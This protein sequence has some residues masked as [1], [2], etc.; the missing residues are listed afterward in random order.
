MK[1]KSR[2]GMGFKK[3]RS[4]KRARVGK[5]LKKKVS[6]NK[7]S[8]S[9]V[10]KSMPSKC[11]LKVIRLALKKARSAVKEAGGK[12]NIEIP[13]ILPVPT[14]TDGILS[15]VI[16]LFAGLSATGALTG[17]AAGIAKAVNDAK[18]AK[19]QLEENKRH[20]KTM[21]SVALGNGLYL[22][23]HKVGLGLH[24][25]KMFDQIKFPQRVLTDADILKYAK[26][27]K[28]PNFR[29]VFMRNALPASEPRYSE[30]A[31]VNLDN[32]SG[33][34]THWVV[35]R[36][37]G[38]NVVYY[39]SF[40]DLRPPLDLILYL[41]VDEV[42]YNQERFQDFDIYNCGHLCLKFLCAA[43]PGE[44]GGILCHSVLSCHGRFIDSY[45]FRHI[46]YTRNTV[47]STN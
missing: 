13:C 10:F 47:F 46:F 42:K 36:K 1:L 4:K 30:L 9:A 41:G 29:G 2:F 21:E 16:P 32:A 19:Q 6:S 34:G 25:K 5:G 12:K 27:L 17:G 15:F 8:K 39:D 20:N 37:R 31:V 28:I 22:K 3:K 18:A 23:P 7:I 24:L 44:V 14:K 43:I 33:P 11:A 26:L 40:G 35:Y 45:T 38:K